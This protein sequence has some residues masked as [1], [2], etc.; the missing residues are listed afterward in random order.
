MADVNLASSSDVVIESRDS[1]ETGNE[2]FEPAS[3]KQRKEESNVEKTKN[4]DER[5]ETR[6]GGILCCSVC[7]D[8]PS[9]AVYQCSNGHLSCVGCF[10]HLLADARM[11]DETATCPNCR[12]EISKTLSSRNLA[13]EKAVSEL[14]AQCRYCSNEY[15]RNTV[16][17]HEKELCEERTTMCKFS[18]IGCQWRGPFH[19]VVVHES[20]CVHPHRSGGE[21]MEYLLN[22]DGNHQEEKKLYGTLFDL[23]SFE[24]IAFSDV[25]LKPYRTDEF[26]HKLYYET[27]RF[28]AFSHQW[29]IKARINADQKDPTQSSERGISYQLILKSKATSPITLYFLMLRGPFGEMQ[30]Q[31]KIYH[32]EFSESNCESPLVAFPLTDSA[33][34]NKVLSGKAINCRLIMFMCPK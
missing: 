23:L 21:L 15:S 8:L 4:A 7:L 20:V 13:V 16:E 26:I 33:E 34:C 30:V 25:Q 28:Y 27:S 19:E 12:T 22:M 11:R 2:A 5:L 9:S 10:N 24:K 31:P 3:K 29:V 18:R 17:K 6:L 1:I 32:F 14:P